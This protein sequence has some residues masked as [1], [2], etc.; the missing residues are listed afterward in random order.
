[1]NE[2]LVAIFRY[3]HSDLSQGPAVRSPL[4]GSRG[5]D[6]YSPYS[7]AQH[8]SYN[9]YDRDDLGRGYAPDPDLDPYARDDPYRSGSALGSR[10]ERDLNGDAPSRDYNDHSSINR[11]QFYPT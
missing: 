3:S 4:D 2:F 5:Y 10:P 9:P 8:R 1:M 6:P 11:Y 7:E